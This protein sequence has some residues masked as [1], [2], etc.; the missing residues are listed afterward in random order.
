MCPLGQNLVRMLWGVADDVKN[1]SDEVERDSGVEQV[2]HRIHEH[3][4]RAGPPIWLSK[5]LGMSGYGES[6][7]GGPRVAVVLVLRN[8][9]G[10]QAFSKSEGVTVVAA[11]GDPVAPSHGVPGCLCPLDT[12]VVRHTPPPCSNG[13]SITSRIAFGAHSFTCFADLSVSV[14]VSASKI[15]GLPPA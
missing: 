14:K 3:D 10:L 13:C 15:G 9:H 2:A 7:S 1:L 8:A 6:G 11:S 5:R 4:S 12:A